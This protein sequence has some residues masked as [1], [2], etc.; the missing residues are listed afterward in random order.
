MKLP[1]RGDD[2]VVARQHGHLLGPAGLMLEKMVDVSE[3]TRFV[4]EVVRTEMIKYEKPCERQ[5]VSR[6][7]AKAA[8]AGFARDGIHR[9][10]DFAHR[11]RVQDWRR[12]SFRPVA[13]V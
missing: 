12:R 1:Q 10:E 2:I 3:M 6:R 13:F 5:P 4:D 11:L 7:Q 9:S 8:G